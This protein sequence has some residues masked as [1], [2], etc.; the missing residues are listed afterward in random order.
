M[1]EAKRARVEAN[2]EALRA[3]SEEAFRRAEGWDAETLD[4]IAADAREAWEAGELFY[5]PI[6]NATARPDQGV[7]RARGAEKALAVI[8][9]QGWRLHT[10]DWAESGQLGTATARPVFTRPQV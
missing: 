1:L 3:Q 4:A 7:R 5:L 6:I 10:W 2:W 8:T 9:Q